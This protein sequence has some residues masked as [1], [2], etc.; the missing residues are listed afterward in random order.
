MGKLR[1]GLERPRKADDDFQRP[2][3]GRGVVGP[4]LCPASVSLPAEG[5]SFSLCVLKRFTVALA[6]LKHGASDV[7][8]ERRADV[9][10]RRYVWCISR[11]S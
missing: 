8:T 6:F 7:Q 10:E 1:H 3:R 9:T 2:L 5:G 4:D 11:G